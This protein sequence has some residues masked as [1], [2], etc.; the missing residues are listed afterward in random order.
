MKAGK[1]LNFYEKKY[2]QLLIVSF[3]ILA[4]SLAVIGYNLATTGDFID[5]GISLKGGITVT[6]L[7]EQPI[8]G[9]ELRL[10]LL[11]ELPNADINVRTTSELGVQKSIIVD[12]SDTEAEELI[13]AIQ[14]YVPDANSKAN[15]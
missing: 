15:I 3:L 1:F 10:Q 9:E 5:K 11:E 6:V 14:N 13:R 8:V 7:T 2:K 12:A 4:L